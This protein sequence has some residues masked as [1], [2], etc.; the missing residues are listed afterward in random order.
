[1]D[2]YLAEQKYYGQLINCFVE[3]NKILKKIKRVLDNVILK[4][5]NEEKH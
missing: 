3:I 5:E 1:M 4:Y 2:N